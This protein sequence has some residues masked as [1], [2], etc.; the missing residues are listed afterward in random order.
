MFLL[1]QIGRVG[2]ILVLVSLPLTLLTGF[3][4]TYVIIFCGVFA[5]A[6]VLIGGLSTV[7]WTEVMQACV[8]LVSLVFCIGLIVWKLPGG[9]GEVFSVGHAAGKFSFPPWHIDGAS[10]MSDLCH[11]PSASC[12]FMAFSINCCT[13]EQ[14]R[15]SFNGTW[16]RVRIAP[17]AKDSG[18]AASVSSPCSWR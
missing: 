1:L 9:F 18:S 2:L 12:S 3:E 16:P 7:L 10:P 15:M 14:I 8:L 6:Y 11:S 4:Q 17:P 13:T 5:T